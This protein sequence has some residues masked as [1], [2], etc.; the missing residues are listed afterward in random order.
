MKVYG[1]RHKS[2]KS[3][4]KLS[5][6][7]DHGPSDILLFLSAA[8]A[9]EVTEEY[10]PQF[11]AVEVPP[12]LLDKLQADSSLGELQQEER[13]C[14][15]CGK[16]TQQNCIDF[17]HERDSSQDWR[18]CLECGWTYHGFTGKWTPPPHG[19]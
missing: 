13:Y 3:W 16:D 12:E 9:N 8:R 17:N 4:L 11:E 10:A 7:N 5:D 1:L 6:F 18:K 14:G 15:H 19:D 2:G